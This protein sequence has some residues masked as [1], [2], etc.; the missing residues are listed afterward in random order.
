MS[1]KRKHSEKCQIK[2]HIFALKTN[3]FNTFGYQLINYLLILVNPVLPTQI[4]FNNLY[5][6]IYKLIKTEEYDKSK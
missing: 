3:T 6:Y 1:C 5:I 4:A 2:R